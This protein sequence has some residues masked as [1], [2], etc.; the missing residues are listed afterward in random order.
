MRK[1][2]LR[3]TR[4]ILLFL[5]VVSL[6]GCGFERGPN[7]KK[8]DDEISKA[9]YEKVGKKVSYERRNETKY[10]ALQYCYILLDN[11]DDDLLADMAEAIN[12]VLVDNDIGKIDL[13]IEEE[14]HPFSHESV[15]SLSNYNYKLIDPYHISD[16]SQYGYLYYL[17]IYGN[18]GNEDSSYNQPSSYPALEGI[19]YLRVIDK[20]NKNA[21]EEGIDWYEVF[22]D[23]KGYEVYKYENGERTIIYQEMKEDEVSE[24]SEETEVS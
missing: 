12:E 5:L 7:M 2:R 10:G 13:I 14:S 22:P 16:D 17:S 3:I 15:L 11:D 24:N 20:V 18:D 23:L 9:I 8:A 21:E 6:P 19:E 1:R 4:W